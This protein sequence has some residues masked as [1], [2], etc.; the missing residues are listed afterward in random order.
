MLDSGFV[1]Q[2]RRTQP[3]DRSRIAL[4]DPPSLTKWIL[5]PES[6]NRLLLW[7]NPDRDLAGEKY[8]E[9]RSGL[10]KRFRQLGRPDGEELANKT[11][12]RVAKKLPA[13]VDKYIGEPEPYV[14]TIAYN[15]YRE[16]LRKPIMMSLE[17]YNFSQSTLL[18]PD[19]VAEKD[20][21]NDCLQECL[22]QLSESSRSL[23]TIYY[24]GER[25]DKIRRRKE[26]AELLGIKL[27]NLRLRA[28]RIRT[29]LK[30]CIL[31]CMERKASEREVLM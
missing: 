30:K 21:L 2:Q 4:D 26:L 23:I 24:H 28:Q 17:N 1:N 14:F 25:W 16:D 10:I 5:T 7:L 27:T 15:I 6:F 31:D 9:I 8:E 3:P 29:S 12:D 20:L 11:F 13:V 18:N 19:E 22:R